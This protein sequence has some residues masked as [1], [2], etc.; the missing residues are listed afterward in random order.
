MNLLLLILFCII[1]YYL[2]C[3]YYNSSFFLKNKTNFS[4]LNNNELDDK[5]VFPKILFQTYHSISKIPKYIYD[6]KK[7]FASNYQ[8]KIYDDVSGLEFIEKYFT[9]P[10]VDKFKSLKGA[11]KADLLRYCLLYIYGGVYLDIKS[12]LTK[13]LDSFLNFDNLDSHRLYTVKSVHL[14]FPSVYQGFIAT[15]KNNPLFITLINLI[16]Q[17]P[18]IVTKLCYHVFTMQMYNLI[19]NNPIENP[20]IKETCKRGNDRHSLKCIVIDKNNIKL[21]D[22]RDP[23][24]PY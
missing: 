14:L 22:V 18:E 16:L 11:H 13:D 3:Y 9:Q 24:Y 2:L 17:T 21:F 10:V 8:H 20:L 7:E 6:N 15:T 19:K 12:I 23:N 4:I 5:F 1:I